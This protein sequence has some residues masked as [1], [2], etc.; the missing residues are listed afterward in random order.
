M[1]ELL[2]SNKNS[3]GR[4]DKIIFKYL[5]KAPSSFVYK[6]LRKKNIVLNDK[7][8]SGNEIL[9]DGD[10][11]KIYLADETLA[12]FKSIPIEKGKQGDLSPYI[13]FEDDN[14]IALNK[15][16]GMLTQKSSGKDISLNDLLI[17][18]FDQADELF[19]PGISNR[20]DRNTSGLVLA[21]KNLASTRDLNEIIKNRWLNKKYICLVKGRVE[22]EQR[23]IAYLSKNEINNQVKISLQPSEAYPHKIITQFQPLKANDDYTVLE[24][25]LITGK[26][27]QIRAHL[28]YL[29]HPLVGD[30]K[31][32]DKVTNAYFRRNY[33]LNSQFLHAYK[34]DFQDITNTLEY[35]NGVTITAPVPE[36]LI[37]ILK[38]EKLCLPG[39][40]ED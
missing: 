7:K 27:H 5:D 29:G 38:G 1:I 26:S 15:P 4:L 12:K 10:S 11:I 22:H 3:G 25:D 13:F 35:L 40:A 23:A 34:I 33:G 28:A 6:M 18:Y 21:G 9:N 14:I 24:V 31:Y 20:L 17:D 36:N 30:S 37:K 32:G 16:S 19:K 8:A 2:I 39:I